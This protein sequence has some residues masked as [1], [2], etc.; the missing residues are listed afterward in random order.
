MV[1]RIRDP[2]V[3]EE[4]AAQAGTE[5]TP[6]LF[7]NELLTPVIF[8]PQR[9]PLATAGYFPGCMGV[10]VAAVA[11][12][13]SLV[14]IRVNGVNVRA[15][16][17]VTS[18]RIFNAAQTART[19]H[20][21]RLDDVS[22]VSV[23]PLVPGYIDAGSAQSGAVESMIRTNLTTVSGTLMA[24]VEVAPESSDTFQGPWIINNG[25]LLVTPSAVNVAVQAYFSYEH[26][27]AIRAQPV[28]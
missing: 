1:E 3:A 23:T 9:P 5:E 19:Y 11:S 6:P 8:G 2:K 25:G 4:V 14:G 17:R 13:F 7:L 21:R 26:W 28:G 24:S 10:A 20:I 22:G 16:V 18:I 27:L 15:I 12:N